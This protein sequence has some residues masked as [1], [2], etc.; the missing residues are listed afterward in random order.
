MKEESLGAWMKKFLKKGK[1][2]VV[3]STTGNTFEGTFKGLKY[4]NL[5]FLDPEGNNIY[6][7]PSNVEVI[8][9]MKGGNE[10]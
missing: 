9:E 5:H 10:Q 1:E 7:N 6:F 2:Y 8:F 3:I 4:G